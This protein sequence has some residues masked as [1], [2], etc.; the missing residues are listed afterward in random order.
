MDA[1]DAVDRAM[2]TQLQVDGRVTATE[3]A[4]RVGLSTSACVRRIQKL[5][6][7]GFIDRYVMLMDPRSIGLSASVFVEITL[8]SQHEDRLDEF[9]AAVVDCPGVMSCH[10]MAGDA[11]Y[12]IHLVCEGVADYERIHRSHLAQLPG[13]A[14]LRSN[15]A[16]RTVTDTTAYP[17]S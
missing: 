9:E 7:E 2:L 10:L 16:I 11:D 5:E 13:V 3:L 1:L 14:R 6:D 15:F 12:I 17:L 8:A 4:D